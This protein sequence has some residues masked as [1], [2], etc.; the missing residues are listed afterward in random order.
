MPTLNQPFPA[1]GNILGNPFSVNFHHW[2]PE[3][4]FLD[5][6]LS[7][8]NDIF[9]NR[10]NI[11][12]WVCETTSIPAHWVENSELFDE[13][14][15]ASTFCAEV[16]RR[17]GISRPVRVLPHVMWSGRLLRPR[18]R[19]RCKE[20]FHFLCVYDSDSRISRKN[21]F[22]AIR[23]FLRAFPE[24]E[25]V[26]LTVKVR[27]PRPGEVELLRGVAE[28][29]PRVSII[30]QELSDMKMRQLIDST[31]ALVSLHRGEGF[32]MHIAEAMASGLPVI[33]TA[34][35]GSMDF[36]DSENSLLVEAHRTDVRDVYFGEQSGEWWEPNEEHARIQ[37]RRLWEDYATERISNLTDRAKRV[38]AQFSPEAVE[39]TARAFLDPF[40]PDTTH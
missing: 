33:V 16:F 10:I 39:L 4:E 28:Q 14:W 31:D 18:E 36:T 37:M 34:G 19:A 11:A 12:F 2:H 29:D 13:V 7:N 38:A 21:P 30:G 20:G 3:K 24:R 6:L 40:C 25:K 26:Q 35:G 15:T 5:R 9:S 22:A 8:R 27:H 17:A 32:G 1:A 23:T